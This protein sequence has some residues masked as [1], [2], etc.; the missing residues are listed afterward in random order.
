MG[1]FYPI[2]RRG[3][4]YVNCTASTVFALQVRSV[5]DMLRT[6]VKV[7]TYVSHLCQILTGL[8]WPDNHYY[9]R[10][11]ISYH[12]SSCNDEHV[13]LT[14][15]GPLRFEEVKLLQFHV[16]LCSQ[17]LTPGPIRSLIHWYSSS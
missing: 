3:D 16:Y 12:R 17:N 11:V 2:S 1:S 9:M 8:D 15:F 5:V 6:D 14:Y 7:R 4:A 13:L 10:R